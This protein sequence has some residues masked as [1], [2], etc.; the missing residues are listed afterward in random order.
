[1]TKKKK[2]K[3]D[4][5]DYPNLDPSMNIKARRDVADSHYYVKGVK[6]NEGCIVIPALDADSKEYLNK[7]TAEYYN[8]N[9]SG[10]DNLHPTLID[11]AT[12]EDVKEQIRDIKKKRREIFDKSPNTTTQEDRDTA[13]FLTT[14]IEE[15]EYF[16]NKAYPQR[17]A[18]K[19][20]NDRNVDLL[21]YAKRSNV[22][23]AVSWEE[24]VDADLND[25]Q[26][27][28]DFGEKREWKDE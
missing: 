17:S 12:I 7:F 4:K 24:L 15:I 13:N 10:D 22:Y 25:V 23:T 19:A 27:D 1:M 9:F 14:Q 11:D 3:R 2:T 6:D 26:L 28:Y 20:N 16:L 8:A 18:E 21:N 5:S